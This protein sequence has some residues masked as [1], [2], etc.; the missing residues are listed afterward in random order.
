MAKRNN[1]FS[2]G[3][4]AEGCAEAEVQWDNSFVADELD[5]AIHNGITRA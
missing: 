3:D 4:R 2:T 1:G 5:V